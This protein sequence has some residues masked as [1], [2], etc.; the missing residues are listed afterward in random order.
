MVLSSV[1]WP[2]PLNDIF[3]LIERM[4]DDELV[5]LRALG[6]GLLS[7]S[8]VKDDDGD[9]ERVDDLKGNSTPW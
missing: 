7:L 6:L 1:G 8:P 4:M 2:W 3:L 5:L 9:G